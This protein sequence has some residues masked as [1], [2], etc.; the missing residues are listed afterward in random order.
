MGVHASPSTDTHISPPRLGC[1][2]IYTQTSMHMWCTLADTLGS[3]PIGAMYAYVC[4]RLH[5]FVN[6]CRFHECLFMREGLCFCMR[7]YVCVYIRYSPPCIFRK[8]PWAERKA[9]GKVTGTQQERMREAPE[10]P[11]SRHLPPPVKNGIPYI[12]E[13]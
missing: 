4:V 8:L 9:E 11:K 12:L 5:T 7:V 2:F 1:K 13:R 6:V 10:G 3:T